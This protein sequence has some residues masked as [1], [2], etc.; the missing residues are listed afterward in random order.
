[1]LRLSIN[2]RFRFSAAHQL[3]QAEGSV[4]QNKIYFGEE[5]H[6]KTPHGHNYEAF[7][8]F[9]GAVNSKTGMMMELSA[10]RQVIENQIISRYDHTTLNQIFQMPTA[11][12]VAQQMLQSAV[13]L[14]KNYPVRPMVCH[15]NETESRGAT[16]Y[17]DGSIERQD[18]FSAFI[19]D[20]VQVRIPVAFQITWRSDTV[21]PCG[22]V[23]TQQAVTR[24]IRHA[25]RKLKSV[26]GIVNALAVVFDV[27][28]KVP[29]FHRLKLSVSPYFDLEFDGRQ[30]QLA[31]RYPIFMAHQLVNKR[32]SESENRQF[33]GACHNPHGHA[34]G[35]EATFAINPK[36]RWSFESI[37]KFKAGA[38]LALQHLNYGNMNDLDY[39]K[40]RP[41]T[42]EHFIYY[43]WSLFE[44]GQTEAMPVQRIRLWE[45]ENNRFTLRRCHGDE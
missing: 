14:F 12:N 19:Y 30:W 16:V 10:L 41:C 38:G 2:R 20:G 7:F 9:E 1:M 13:P 40:S 22:T 36:L 27:L 31:L 33:Y 3:W 45:T 8:V 42:G 23:V 15:V 24:A 32:V 26:R 18:A 25:Q 6:S 39:F 17:Q 21:L 34:F 35:L 11:E 44:A 43:L 5:A 4:M 29:T 37:L 28:S